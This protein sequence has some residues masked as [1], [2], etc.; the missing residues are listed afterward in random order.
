MAGYI[1]DYKLDYSPSLNALNYKLQDNR[2]RRENRLALIKSAG[3]LV[4]DIVDTKMKMDM[5]D[6]SEIDKAVKSGMDRNWLLQHYPKQKDYIASL[7]P[8][9]KVVEGG[10]EESPITTRQLANE[11]VNDPDRL[12]SLMGT[13]G[14]TGYVPSSSIAASDLMR[15]YTPVRRGL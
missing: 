3:S 4:G 15:G 11:L 7:F 14:M 6:K 10:E 1:T 5:V 9:V 12:N 8:E 13:I 2:N